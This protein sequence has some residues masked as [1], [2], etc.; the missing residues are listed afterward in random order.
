MLYNAIRTVVALIALWTTPILVA[1]EPIRVAATVPELGSL[2]REIGG[3]Q[4][5]VTVIAKGT[6]DPQFIEAKPSF[7]RTLNQA[8]LYLQLG[9]DMEVGWAPLLLENARNGDVLPG[10]PGYVDAS[11][12]ITPLEVPKTTVD[13]SMGDVHPMGNPHYLT[14]PIQGLY[15]AGL[16]RDKLGQ[17]RPTKKD[18]FT[19]RYDEFA[20]KLVTALVGPELTNKYGIDGVRKLARLPEHGKLI[21][22]LESQGEADLLGGW[23]GALRP[24]YGAKAVADHNMWPYFA[25]RFGI[26]IMGHLEPKPGV[27]PTTRHLKKLIEFMRVENIGIILT[28][29]Y[30][31]P[32]HARFVA[33]NSGAIVVPMAH[34]VGAQVG[35]GDYVSMIDYNVRKLTDAV[36]QK[37]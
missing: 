5:S 1:A 13:R 10:A 12:A 11:V 31:D 2:A 28:A 15:V 3:D 23:L 20:E 26:K 7:I 9:M 25:R 4:V 17:L 33:Q 22:F 32:R 19:A 8:D 14:D 24:Y 34:Q 36:A 6:E 27:P 21:A 29:A 37:T 30:Y 16:I 18:Y 35:T